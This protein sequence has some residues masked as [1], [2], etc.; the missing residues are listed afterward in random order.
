MVFTTDDLAVIVTCFT[1]KGWTG[2]LNPLNYSTC[3]WRKTW[4]VCKPQRSAECY[5]R[6]MAYWWSDNEKS[7]FAV[8]K[9]F[10]SSIA[11]Q[12]R[13]PVLYIFC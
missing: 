7:Y 10:G 1:E 4:A 3:L 12:N 5:Q 13:G 6:Q 11:K 8:E 2:T 9:A